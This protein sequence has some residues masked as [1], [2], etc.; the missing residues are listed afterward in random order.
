MTDH[1][2]DADL[3]RALG[4]WHCESWS[5]RNI[6]G[7]ENPNM[8][9]YIQSTNLCTVIDEFDIFTGRVVDRRLAVIVSGGI[10]V[11]EFT[12]DTWLRLSIGSTFGSVTGMMSATISIDYV[13]TY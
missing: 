13:I 10:V 1:V 11:S 2:G 8:K 9:T 7:T 3:L 12:S 4:A 6:R 5:S